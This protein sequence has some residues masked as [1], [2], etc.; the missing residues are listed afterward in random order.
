MSEAPFSIRPVALLVENFRGLGGEHSLDLDRDLTVLVG[1]N[2][3]GK[4][5]LLVAVEWCLFGAEATRKSDSG[6]AERGDWALAHDGAAGDV[7]VTLELSVEGGRARLT[8]RR[9]AGANPRDEDE[10]RLELPGD[11]VLRGTEVRDWLSWNHLPDWKVWK[12]SFCQ[13][14]ELSRA[15]VTEEADRSTAIAG[16]LGLDEYRK[17]SDELKKLKV[18]K[19]EQR[20]A[21]ELAELQKEYERALERPALELRDLEG[22]LE[23][24]GVAAAQAGDAELAR[25]ATE[26]LASAR[27]I[28]TRLG[29]DGS[30]VPRDDGPAA[31]L[32][33]WAQTWRAEV[34]RKVDALSK[35]CG[36]LSQR[37]QTIE[38]SVEALKPARR[39]EADAKSARERLATELGSVQGLRAQREEQAKKRADLEDE[40]RRRDA[41]GKLLR[42]ALQVVK[43]APAPGPCPVCD[44]DRSDLERVIGE[45]LDAHA[46]DTLQSQLAELEARD[47]KLQE[48]IEQLNSADRACEVARQQV[49]S[50]EENVRGQLPAGTG[51]GTSIDTLL[52]SWREEVRKLRERCDAGERHISEHHENLEILDLLVKLRDARARANATAGE[53]TQTPEFQELQRVIDKAAGLASDLEALG[54]MARKLEDQ[55]SEERIA[56]VNESIDSYFSA[57]TGGWARGRVRVQPKRTATK[58]S[59]QLVDE[60]GRAITSL[61]NQA[62]FNALSLAALLA[63]AESR[64]RLGLP[65]FLVLDDPGQSLDEEHQAGLARAIATF[66]G[67]APV[68]VA[69]F[70]GALADA[71]SKTDAGNPGTFLLARTGDGADITIRGA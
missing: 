68:L 45:K 18:K 69:T 71:L 1:N 5:S 28:A 8:R 70:P 59:Y 22:R 55:R 32:L 19:L 38:A 47:A 31:E 49:H 26:F 11:E 29:V 44:Q 34:R 30:G 48:H 33:P 6:I 60:Q 27:E 57:I 9:A 13:H 43:S 41:L 66:T 36:E 65:Q 10:V 37:V 63:S 58:V 23:R 42:D 14:Q 54:A 7:R 12:R 24:H 52:R 53:L 35:E 3:T 50:L 62:A 67:I 56:A 20:A 39:A 64:A 17:V 25:R 15:R 40:G 4:S 61:L 2:G 16:M 51:E 21:G 46:P